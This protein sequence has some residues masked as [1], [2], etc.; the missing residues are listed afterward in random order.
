MLY[1]SSFL[2]GISFP[3]VKLKLEV[4]IIRNAFASK[5]PTKTNKFMKWKH[6]FIPYKL[7]V[8]LTTSIEKKI[9]IEK[10]K[11]KICVLFE[12]LHI[13]P[14]NLE[15]L[16]PLRNHFY[17]IKL[18]R[19]RYSTWAQTTYSPS[20][21]RKDTHYTCMVKLERRDCSRSGL[22]TCWIT[23]MDDNCRAEDYEDEDPNP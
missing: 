11:S 6:I 14:I 3:L 2:E 17:S 23:T 8:I 4:S 15:I 7:Q 21:R 10:P 9:Y 16:I 20:T 22:S 18:N 19:I 13:L 12:K 5:K 1:Y